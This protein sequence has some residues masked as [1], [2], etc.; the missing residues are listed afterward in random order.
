MPNF[1]RSLFPSALHPP[2]PLQ[3]ESIPWHDD[4]L[5]KMLSLTPPPT[6]PRSPL[7]LVHRGAARS[8]T[9]RGTAPTTRYPTRKKQPRKRSRWM[10]RTTPTTGP[11]GAHRARALR[12]LNRETTAPR[13]G[14]VPGTLRVAPWGRPWWARVG[15]NGKSRSTLVGGPGKVRKGHSFV[16]GFSRR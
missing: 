2:A 1:F 7:P 3:P 16:V 14:G 12:G 5:R 11:P 10:N 8:T 13:L 15:R 6:P 4:C 9:C